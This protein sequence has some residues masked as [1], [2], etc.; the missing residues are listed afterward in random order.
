M[1]S[2]DV[3]ELIFVSALEQTLAA[4]NTIILAEELANENR[5]KPPKPYVSVKMIVGPGA[6]GSDE[7]LRSVGGSFVLSSLRQFT[8]SCQGYGQGVHDSLA[9]FQASLYAM[10]VKADGSLNLGEYLKSVGVSIVERQVVQ[11]L[12]AMLG[13]GFEKRAQLDIIVNIANNESI[14]I[15]VI[16]K[17]TFKGDIVKEDDS[18]YS[19]PQQ[20]VIKP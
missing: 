9:L 18:V 17:V 5:T 4:E 16:E 2:K 10:G 8:I 15:G 7:N 3:L 1:I 11:D 12:T 6:S 13:T 19:V 14:D 20:E